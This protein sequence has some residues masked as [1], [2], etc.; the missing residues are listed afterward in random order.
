MGSSKDGSCGP[1][2]FP[3]RMDMEGGETVRK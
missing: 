3:D 1:G 2:F